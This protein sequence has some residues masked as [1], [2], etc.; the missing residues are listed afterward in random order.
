MTLNQLEALLGT[1]IPLQ[2][3][4]VS[5]DRCECSDNPDGCCGDPD[6]C[7]DCTCALD[8]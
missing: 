2:L 6:S 3:Q 5:F 7:G 1:G 8:G 4:N